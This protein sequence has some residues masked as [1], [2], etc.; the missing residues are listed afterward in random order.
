M[1]KHLPLLAL[2]LAFGAANAS[3]AAPPQVVLHGTVT[4]QSGEHPASLVLM[5]TTGAG[6]A[7]SLQLAVVRDTAPGF[8]FDAFEGPDAPASHV[9]SAVLQVGKHSFPPVAVAGWISGDDPDMFV[10]GIATTPGKHDAITDF[11]AAL[12]PE[13]MLTWAQNS[14]NI[15]TPPLAAQFVLDAA[16]SSELRRIAAPCL[17]RHR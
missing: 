1:R 11:V 6:G 7:L 10:F 17:P 4:T 12:K 3:P 8:P 2:G 14:N 16:Q 15:Q 9:P 13:A 5:C